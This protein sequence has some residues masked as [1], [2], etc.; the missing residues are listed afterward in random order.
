LSSGVP[1]VFGLGQSPSVICKDSDSSPYSTVVTSRIMVIM[2]PEGPVMKMLKCYAYLSE[3][4]QG[5]T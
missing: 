3:I 4:I 5:P 2:S 1:L